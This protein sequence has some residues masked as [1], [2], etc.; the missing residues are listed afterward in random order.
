[1]R[2]GWIGGT[3]VAIFLTGCAL[4]QHA[5]LAPTDAAQPP[6]SS[7]VTLMAEADAPQ[8]L[9]NG[10]RFVAPRGWSIRSERQA[11]ILGAPERDSHIAIVD[12]GSGNA[13]AAVI[14][15][16]RIYRPGFSGTA[17][18]AEGP[19]REGWDRTLLYRYES[20]TR[21]AREVSALALRKGGAG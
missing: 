4:E 3:T 17:R 16:W 9:P 7:S 18:V 14:A 10:T 5:I 8:A 20:P 12:G 21:A 15:A 6:A 2:L 11:V 1:M 13:D 19:T